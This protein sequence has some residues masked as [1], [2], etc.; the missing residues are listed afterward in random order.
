M[1]RVFIADDHPLVRKGLRELLNEELDLKVVGEGTNSSDVLDGLSKHAVDV[2]VTDFSMP[3]RSGFDL[4]ADAK[5]MNAKLKILILSIHPEDRFAVRAIKAGASGYITKDSP[6]E[7]LVAAIR[8]VADG[9]KYVSQRL[10]ER[11][12]DE[13]EKDTERQPLESLSVRELQIMCMIAQ[14]KRVKQIADDLNLS[15]RTINSARARIMRKL[16]MKSN[17]EM[18]YYALKNGLID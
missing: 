2:L 14:G 18:T 7:E 17:V 3:G 16:G 1:I 8:K 10:V 5:R 11:L 4:V 15:F 13:L 12:A 6:P 9:R